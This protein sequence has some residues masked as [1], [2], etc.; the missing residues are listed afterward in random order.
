VTS[1]QQKPAVTDVV[2]AVFGLVTQLVLP[3]RT[4]Q[5]TFPGD[6]VT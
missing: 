2:A 3:R 1:L 4:R 6:P 5:L